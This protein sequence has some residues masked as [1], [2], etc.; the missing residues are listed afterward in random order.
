MAQL[1]A[2][3]TGDRVMFDREP[4]TSA[5]LLPVEL[6]V[7]KVDENGDEI[8]GQLKNTDELKV[9]KWEDAF[10][11]NSHN[12]GIDPN[13]NDNDVD[14]FYF[15][16]QL[17]W[18]KGNGTAQVKIKTDSDPENLIELT[19]TSANSGTFKS[20]ALILVSNDADDQHPANTDE[21]LN[22]I[23]HKVALGDEI[24][25]T[26][27]TPGGA[28][29]TIKATV[30]VR[31][32]LDLDVWRMNVTGVRSLSEVNDA[33]ERIKR[34]YAQVGIQIN[35]DVAEVAWPQ[36]VEDLK[37]GTPRENTP[38]GLDIYTTDPPFAG[39]FTLEYTTFVDSFTDGGSTTV[40]LH[41]LL[42]A[43]TGFGVAVTIKDLPLQPGETD[44]KYVDRAFVH[45]LAGP[46]YQTPSHELLHVLAPESVDHENQPYYNVLTWGGETLPETIFAR[47]RIDRAQEKEI[48][49]HPAVR[50][51]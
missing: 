29:A 31:R 14:R 1:K 38:G 36:A 13:F 19:E 48:Y 33:V 43:Y 22:D 9:A 23:T 25:F 6:L 11:G 28:D 50:T 51:P 32:E 4:R 20:K 16:A 15:R 39:P 5:L 41:F 34:T 10:T 2:S 17:P 24:T 40:D 30:P 42:A 3:S 49:E 35:A 26:I 47:K 7:P 44:Y 37:V 18:E 46:P 21:Q 8:P 12:P 45:D 27:S